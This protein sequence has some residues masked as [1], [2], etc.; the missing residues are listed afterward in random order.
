M[1]IGQRLAERAAAGYRGA[2]TSGRLRHALERRR[3]DWLSRP[4]PTHIEH[5][6]SEWCPPGGTFFEAGA[7]D[8]YTA[9]C[10]YYLAR[11][12]SCSGVLVEPVPEQYRRCV[13]ERPE[14]KVF[15]YAL[16]PPE[17]AGERIPFQYAELMTMVVGQRDPED[18]RAQLEFARERGVEMH[19]FEAEGRTISALLEEAGVGEID[20]MSL[21]LEGYEPL[22]IRGLDIAR[23]NPRYLMTE[24]INPRAGWPAF[25]E[26]LGDAYT[27]AG[28]VTP[29]D[30]L[31]VRRGETMPKLWTHGSLG[32]RSDEVS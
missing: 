11:F 19:S 14:S 12:L 28:W 22:A 18:E 16:V 3:L 32:W 1:S 20:F 13:R 10:T 9:S 17:L 21:D 4:T 29:F 30:Y 31:Y 23:H 15:N 27:A 6:I 26:H 2:R 25:A 5:W 7:A 24:M 8:G